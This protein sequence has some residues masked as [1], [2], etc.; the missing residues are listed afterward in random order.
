MCIRDS[1]Q[2]ILRLPHFQRI[3]DPP[4]QHC[5]SGQGRLGLRFLSLLQFRR[6]LYDGHGGQLLLRHQ[7]PAEFQSALRITRYKGFLESLEYDTVV[8]AARFRVH[9]LCSLGQQT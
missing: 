1:L 8:L 7:N 5:G 3:E 9:A 6:L 4:I 2:P